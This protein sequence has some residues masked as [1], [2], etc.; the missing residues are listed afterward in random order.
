MKIKLLHEYAERIHE[1]YP[2]VDIESI[3]KIL[4]Y[5][6]K[7]FVIL[8]RKKANIV[9][10][11]I[12]QGCFFHIGSIYKTEEAR[13]K[14]RLKHATRKVR[15]MAIVRQEKYDGH[16][17]FGLSEEKHEEFIQTGIIDGVVLYRL[18]KELMLHKYPH[19]YK[20]KM[21]DMKKWRIKTEKY[22]ANNAKHL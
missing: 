9:I 8:K 18:K 7:R 20:V 6:A 14:M 3:I 16:M 5:G 1:I 17:Y 19:L 11:D 13:M 4:K 12:H 22:E 10:R 15:R 2:N 21:E